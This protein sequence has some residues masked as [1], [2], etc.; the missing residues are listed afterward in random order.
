MFHFR[1]PC[2]RI[3]AQSCFAQ[4]IETPKK[5]YE[6]L[7]NVPSTESFKEIHTEIPLLEI[8]KN[9]SAAISSSY[10]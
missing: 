2:P 10:S 5:F 1:V 6:M 8:L 7:N 9:S 4:N 3:E